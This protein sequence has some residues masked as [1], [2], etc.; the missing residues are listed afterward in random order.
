MIFTSN[1]KHTR[2]VGSIGF[3]EAVLANTLKF[4]GAKG[5]TSSPNLYILVMQ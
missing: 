4:D 3:R 1:K 5:A 2:I